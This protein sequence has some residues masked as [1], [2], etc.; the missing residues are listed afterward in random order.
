MKLAALVESRRRNHW[1]VFVVI[2]GLTAIYAG[3]F[4]A[5]QGAAPTEWPWVAVVPIPFFLHAAYPTVLGWAVISC[6][7]FV[8]V[9]LAYAMI[10]REMIFPNPPLDRDS[11]EVIGMT[12]LL[13]VLTAVVLFLV[14]SY[15]RKKELSQPSQPSPPDVAE[16]KH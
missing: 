10:I 14:R 5:D 8:Y 2:G 7:I 4:L 12:V 16:R 3:W 6:P 15:P 13:V 11:S 1:Y 9:A